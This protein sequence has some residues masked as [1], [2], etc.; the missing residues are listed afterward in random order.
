MNVLEHTHF[1][2][3][4]VHCSWKCQTNNKNEGNTARMERHCNKTCAKHKQ[5][6]PSSANFW[7]RIEL[8][9]SKMH[10][11]RNSS[12]EFTFISI[13]VFA[14]CTLPSLSTIV[15]LL[16]LCL[17][18]SSSSNA[19]NYRKIKRTFFLK[20]SSWCD[21]SDVAK[22]RANFWEKTNF[23]MRKEILF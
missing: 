17:K 6:A 5:M 2:R 10:S 8:L 22:Q 21:W 19:E 7:N 14:V 3:V 9:K 16:F 18:D 15:Y 23:C 11:Q 13:S 20:Q 1:A 4:V 12:C